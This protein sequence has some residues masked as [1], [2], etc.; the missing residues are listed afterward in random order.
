MDHINN[1]VEQETDDILLKIMKNL[2]AIDSNTDFTFT[3]SI[4][5]NDHSTVNNFI[6][7]LSLSN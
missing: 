7:N 1:A 5:N 6:C 4:E 2:Q 3:D